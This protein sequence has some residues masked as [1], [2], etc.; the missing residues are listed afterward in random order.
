MLHH[1]VAIRSMPRDLN[2]RSKLPRFC[3]HGHWVSRWICHLGYT[4]S[5]SDGE[6]VGEC[7]L[8]H[9][10]WKE[11]GDWGCWWV[12]CFG[13]MPSFF[14]SSE[15]TILLMSDHPYSRQRMG[16]GL[17][18]FVVGLIVSILCVAYM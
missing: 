10:C 1:D 12:V 3:G 15:R 4:S 8:A 9:G 14:I 18:V 17:V 2:G 5:W 16:S 6:L 13:D 11:V 7:W